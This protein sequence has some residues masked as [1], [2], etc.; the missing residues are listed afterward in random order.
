IVVALGWYGAFMAVH[1]ALASDGGRLVTAI[2]P[3][4]GPWLGPVQW[5]VYSCLSIA[6]AVSN[7]WRRT[8]MASRPERGWAS[9]SPRSG[10][11]RAAS[12]RSSRSTWSSTWWPSRR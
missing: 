8:G 3:G 10:S 12:G 6:A 5:A 9:P 7:G 11:S 2:V 1:V 4:I